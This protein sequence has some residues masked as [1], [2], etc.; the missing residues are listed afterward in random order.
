MRKTQK[1]DSQYEK[2]QEYE[3]DSEYELNP[4]YRRDSDESD[5]EKGV[6]A[7]FVAKSQE[8]EFGYCFVSGA[9]PIE[10]FSGNADEGLLSWLQ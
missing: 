1:I 5:D 7:I 4:D 9:I 6:I 3:T 2:D 8:N 10:D